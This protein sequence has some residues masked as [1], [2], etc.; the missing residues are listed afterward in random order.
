MAEGDGAR[1][2]VGDVLS[3]EQRHG[4]HGEAHGE[5]H[6]HDE[7]AHVPEDERRPQP[8]QGHEGPPRV[9]TAGREATSI[10]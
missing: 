6:R 5:Q 4:A 2:G 9:V 7:V 10:A 1:G 3:R 8:K